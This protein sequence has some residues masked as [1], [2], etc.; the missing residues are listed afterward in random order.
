M[1]VMGWRRISNISMHQLGPL[2]RQV[3]ESVRGMVAGSSYL[4]W[5]VQLRSATKKA[6]GS[7]SNGRDSMGRRLGV[8]RFGGQGVTAGTIIIRQRGLK[9]RPGDGVGQGK[10]H[11]LYA[12]RDG[13]VRFAWNKQRKRQVVGVD[14]DTT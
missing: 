10:D 1:I 4:P 12:L 14:P 11:T 9:F 3:L 13:R 7:S 5:T 6:G 2:P 8:K